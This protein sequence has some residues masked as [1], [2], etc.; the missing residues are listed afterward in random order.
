[1]A[2]WHEFMTEGL[3]H[4]RAHKHAVP[5][6]LARPNLLAPRTAAQ[7][8][9][10]YL[11]QMSA[12][13]SIFCQPSLCLC[14]VKV[15]KESCVLAAWTSTNQLI[16]EKH[17]LEGGKTNKHIRSKEARRRTRK[18]RGYINMHPA[19]DPKQFSR[20]A[21]HMTACFMAGTNP[22]STKNLLRS[23]YR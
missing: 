4:R 19:V 16:W 14:S 1:M 6:W 2:N 17:Q 3:Y 7:S 12:C 11:F 8:S 22:Q 23:V 21:C 9:T 5:R 10:G 18:A 20:D 13:S 15:N